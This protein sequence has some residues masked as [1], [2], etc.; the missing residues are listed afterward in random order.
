M[1]DKIKRRFFPGD[2]WI[3][4]KI[5]CG[6]KISN[7][8]LIEII[9]PFTEELLKEK[10]IKKWFFIRYN[11]PNYHIRFRLELSDKKNIGYVITKLNDLLQDYLKSK[12]I[13]SIQIDCYER[14]IERYGLN[15]IELAEDVFFYD[16]TEIIKFLA[17]SKKNDIDLDEIS[18]PV[19]SLKLIDSYLSY[20]ALS[21]SHKLKL[22]ENL[23]SS[24]YKEFE[25][26][27]DNKKQIEEVFTN[28]KE[29]I[30]DKLLNSVG[31]E[32]NTAKK[33]TLNEILK[34]LKNDSL[35]ENKLFYLVS[36]FIH[37]SLNRLYYSNNRIHELVCYDV[38]WKFYKYKT[39]R[40]S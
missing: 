31:S 6:Y 25:I 34:I 37:M 28:H 1:I 12:S 19:F 29:S 10:Q 13:W 40:S 16:S 39:S 35:P 7:T 24:F 14:E 27:K 18:K 4:Y 36:S 2:E 22:M 15:T 33:E 9:K 38:M 26:N 11:D 17:A 5:Y 30:Y 20:F 3:Y 8:I 21:D 23:R 32:T